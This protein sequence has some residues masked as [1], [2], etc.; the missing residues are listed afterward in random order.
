MKRIKFLWTA[1]LMLLCSPLLLVAK[2]T[3]KPVIL[4]LYGT[5]DIHGNFFSY[6]FM[7]DKTMNGGLA[8]IS[9][10]LS[11][12]RAKYGKENCLLLDNGDILQG[13]PC[14]YYS[15]FVD[16]TSPLLASEVMNYLGCDVTTFGNHD[17]EAGTNVFTRWQKDAKFPIIS[18]N[19]LNAADKSN[20]VKT[21]QIFE[22]QGVKIAVL[23]LI[24]PAIPMWVPE[25]LWKGLYFE[26]I[27]QAAKKWVPVIKQ[28]EKPDVLIGLF[29]TGWGGGSL[30][31]YNENAAKAI[32]TEVPGF[33]AIFF[34]HDHRPNLQV[35]T[36][37]DGQ[38][39]C[40][41][42]AGPR[43]FKISE[44]TVT[45]TP[46]KG[47]NYD[48]TVSGQ[49]VDMKDYP[50]DET[51]LAHFKHYFDETKAFVHQ[52][53][54]QVDKPVECVDAFFG[55]S[56][57]AD[58]MHNAQF[59]NSDADISLISPLTT[60]QVIPSSAVS[61]PG[62]PEKLYVKDIFTIYP[63]E[64]MIDILRMSGR[65]VKNSLEA[66]YDLWI[67]TMESPKDHLIQLRQTPNGKYDL[68][69]F[70]SYMVQAA[71]ITYEVDVTKHKGERIHILKMSN[72]EPFDLNK[73]YKVAIN[74][75]LGCGGGGILTT[76]GGIPLQELP[77]RILSTSTLDLRH[78]IMEYVKSLNGK[79]DIQPRADW[80]FI[81]DAFVKEAAL[82]DRTLL[83][84]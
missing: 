75:Y 61:K 41:L 36:N 20:Y 78:Y 27:I 29:H 73:D 10:Y 5:T 68:K 11:R 22:R 53:I 50:M 16:T 19:I 15:N 67:N 43:G 62:T 40:L 9:T 46:V 38:K 72:G 63:Y 3:N 66:S 35:I 4:H 60:T 30:N 70:C 76:G 84:Q 14:V 58:L 12:Q 47:K 33:N 37:K 77:K 65:E 79:W 51:Y 48:V 7:T 83:L 57:V 24:T 34:G 44:A 80:K 21:Y 39:V 69:N 54:G 13:Q 31:N 2:G 74:S 8:R 71:G 81:P 28:K 1:V 82:E 26:D 32:A 17:I 6:D 52:E 42:N 56:T 55:P 25:K 49:L 18:A 64:N 59:L 23:G 45:C